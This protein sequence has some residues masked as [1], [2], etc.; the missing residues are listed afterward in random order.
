ML[1]WLSE[2]ALARAL[3]ASSTLYVLA[4]AAHILSIGLLI[5]SIV[6]LDLRLLGLFRNA[7]LAV[8]GPFLSRSA[9]IG[10]VLSIMTGT[11][12]FTVNAVE[13]ATN[14]PFLLKLGLLAAGIANALLVHANPGWRVALETGKSPLSVKVGAALS[15]LIWTSAVI[16]GRWIGFV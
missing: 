3:I 7:Q 13:Y 14:L 10:A 4:N 6:P 9:M 12:L 2:S 1:E 8:L 11:A 16:A 5:G 15:L